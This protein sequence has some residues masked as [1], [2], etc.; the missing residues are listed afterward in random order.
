[1]T[2]AITVALERA[3]ALPAAPERAFALLADVPRWAEWF[4]E[5]EAIEALPE[6]GPGVYRWT[7]APQG[8]KGH[9]TQTVYACRYTSDAAAHVLTWT[10]VE[11]EGNATFEGETR[12]TP[13]EATTDGDAGS[14]AGRLRLKATLEL[15][16]PPFV[17]PFVEPVVEIAFQ[18]AVTKF[19]ENVRAAL[20]A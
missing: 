11:G 5:V 3:F 10:P 17:R 12:L 15:E 2:S 9:T 18:S 4:P 7:M 20:A 1:M 13:A 6:R 14:S 16:L 19:L 8:P